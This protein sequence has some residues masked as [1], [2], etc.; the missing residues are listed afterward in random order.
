MTMCL[1]KRLACWIMKPEVL[2]SWNVTIRMLDDDKLSST[3]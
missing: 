3:L 2:L 1:E